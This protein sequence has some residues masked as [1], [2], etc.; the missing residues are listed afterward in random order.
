[1]KKSSVLFSSFFIALVA[2]TSGKL[3]YEDDYSL[4]QVNSVD[5]KYVFFYSKPYHPHDTVFK[6][7]TA[8]FGNSADKG[9]RAAMKKALKLANE[10]GVEFDALITG[11]A[12]HD[13]AIKFK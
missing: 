10:R 11:H 13:Y 7:T 1:M 12:Q 2:L 6:I 8:V 3:K 9:V 4:A 5:G